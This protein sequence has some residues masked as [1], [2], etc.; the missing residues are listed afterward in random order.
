MLLF[1]V[2]KAAVSSAACV[3]RIITLISPRGAM[4]SPAATSAAANFN[5]A[6][7]FSQP[8]HIVGARNSCTYVVDQL[9]S[10]LPASQAHHKS[11]ITAL[12]NGFGEHFAEWFG[13]DLE[14]RL[15]R[16]GGVT[17]FLASTASS[18]T[19]T[20]PSETTTTTA[21]AQSSVYVDPVN[22]LV[23]ALFNVFTAAEH[24]RQGLSKH[25]VQLTC[26]FFDRIGGQLMVLGTGSPFAARTCVSA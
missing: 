26:D 18:N 6:V 22:P 5:A 11:A 21:A 23:G 9:G 15:D 17:T 24:R 3:R 2:Q 13:R 20:P 16:D 4:D 25:L 8:T 1:R 10:P 19:V 14:C 12:L 7:R